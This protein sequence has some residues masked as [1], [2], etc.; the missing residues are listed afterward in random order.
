M[1]VDFIQK[2]RPIRNFSSNGNIAQHIKIIFCHFSEA[3]PFLEKFTFGQYHGKI[4][5]AK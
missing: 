3:G 5:D 2:D 1:F 4:A